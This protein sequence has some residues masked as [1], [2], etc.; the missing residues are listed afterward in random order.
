MPGPTDAV[1]DAAEALVGR[2]LTLR[3]LY[4]ANDLSFDA[5]GRVS[6]A[7]KTGDW[8]LAGVNVLKVERRGPKTIEL[9]GV[10]V[11]IRYNTDNHQFE[12][13]PQNDEKM[14]L[15]VADPG[16]LPGWNAAVDKIFAQGID[17]GLQR[18]MP[19]FWQHY[20]N[21]ALAWPQDTLTGQTIYSLFGQP[22]QAKDVTPP[23][24]LHKTDSKMTSFAEHDKVHGVLQLRMVIDTQGV[25]RRIAIVRPIGY[26]LDELAV[27]A[28]TKWQFR[29]GMRSGQPVAV[30]MLLNYDFEFVAPPHP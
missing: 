26:G 23:T 11:A 1:L 25:P 14:K 15:L 20:F 30:E 7:S 10:R 4:L 9:D 28:V 5:A 2:A 3:G 6:G 29:P 12:R 27:E 16:G 17:P 21:P 19:P 13:H 8:T 22:G 24:V 18:A